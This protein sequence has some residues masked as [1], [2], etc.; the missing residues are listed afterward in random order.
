MITRNLNNWSFDRSGRRYTVQAHL[1]A[2][3]PETLVLVQELARAHPVILS[4][5]SR[6]DMGHAVLCTAADYI[7]HHNRVLIRKIIV[8]D[9]WPNEKN[10][11][12]NGRLEYHGAELAH[13]TSAHWLV[14][15]HF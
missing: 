9:P 5:Q 13:K 14:R 4:Y 1:G 12:Q 2:G 7:I 3:A 15:V 8:R 11:R 10:M 6:P